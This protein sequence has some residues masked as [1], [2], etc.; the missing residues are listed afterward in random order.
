MNMEEGLSQNLWLQP[1]E[2]IEDS[3]SPGP[4]ASTASTP[5]LGLWTR[6]KDNRRRR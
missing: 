6:K 5:G 2:L 4:V 1:T 3:E